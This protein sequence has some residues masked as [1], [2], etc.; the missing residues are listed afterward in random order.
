V[1]L[2]PTRFGLK[3]RRLRVRWR[4]LVYRRYAQYGIRLDRSYTGDRW[5]PVVVV[6]A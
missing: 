1:G 4:R 3:V 6:R 2:E 5:N